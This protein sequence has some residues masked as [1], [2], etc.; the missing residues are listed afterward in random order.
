[1]VELIALTMNRITR[2][3][4]EPA[5]RN[6]LLFHMLLL[7]ACAGFNKPAAEIT[8]Y[9]G[10]SCGCCSAWLAHLGEY[11]IR[12]NTVIVDKL[13]KTREELGVPSNFN[14]CHTASMGRYFIEGHIPAADIIKLHDEQPDIEGIAIVGIPDSFPGT[15]E[16]GSPFEVLAV[17]DKNASLKIFTAYYR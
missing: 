15:A 8:L 17:V 14:G 10:N 13:S 11:N 12:V 16:T 5:I 2:R 6:L 1:M 9:R 4:P 7:S 3:M